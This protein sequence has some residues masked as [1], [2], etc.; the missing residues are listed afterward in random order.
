VLVL[1]N[2]YN[3]HRGI[4]GDEYSATILFTTFVMVALAAAHLLTPDIYDTAPSP[5][6]ACLSGGSK[7]A[8]VMLLLLLLPSSSCWAYSPSTC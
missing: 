7:G 8:S 4:R 6:V 2:D 3:T 5:V 1:S